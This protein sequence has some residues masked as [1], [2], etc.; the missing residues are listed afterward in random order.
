MDRSLNGQ[1]TLRLLLKAAPSSLMVQD[2]HGYSPLH[3][4]CK[5]GQPMSMIRLFLLTAPDCI[6]LVV[7]TNHVEKD[8]KTK[9]DAAHFAR[10]CTAGVW[11]PKQQVAIVDYLQNLALVTKITIARQ[12]SCPCSYLDNNLLR[13][14]DVGATRHIPPVVEEYPTNEPFLVLVANHND[15]FVVDNDLQWYNNPLPLPTE[16]PAPYDEHDSTPSSS[17]SFYFSNC[18]SWTEENDNCSS[19][20]SGETCSKVTESEVLS[21]TSTEGVASMDCP[22]VDRR[23]GSSLCQVGPSAAYR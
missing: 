4:A 18:K 13:I 5:F 20:F 1:K 19:T 7:P 17:L 3:L 22:F 2:I 21:E 14:N 15:D 8:D 16:A 23:D 9:K 11:T 10:H 6:V 12:G